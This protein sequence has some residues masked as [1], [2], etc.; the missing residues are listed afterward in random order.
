VA[1]RAGSAGSAVS[2]AGGVVVGLGASAAGS[3]SGVAV[4]VGSVVE[5]SVT[6]GSADDVVAVAKGSVG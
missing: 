3:V 1:R 2:S 6:D 4:V 5:I